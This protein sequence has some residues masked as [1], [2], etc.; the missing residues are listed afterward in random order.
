MFLWSHGRPQLHQKGDLVEITK[1]WML[2]ELEW[3]DSQKS[4]AEQCGATTMAGA[5]GALRGSD[6][7]VLPCRVR[8]CFYCVTF[9]AMLSSG[10]AVGVKT[11]AFVVS[12]LLVP[13]CV[14]LVFQLQTCNLI[15]AGVRKRRRRLQWVPLLKVAGA[16]GAPDPRSSWQIQE[17]SVAGEITSTIDE[18]GLW[19]LGFLNVLAT[20]QKDTC[21]F[22]PCRRQ[23]GWSEG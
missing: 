21:D 22:R 17:Q 19:L 7:G 13:W 15:A 18:E 6:N 1:Y 3:E 20:A 10:S 5:R 11:D 16:L 4:R 12:L 23:H 8:V 2:Q 9:L 14:L